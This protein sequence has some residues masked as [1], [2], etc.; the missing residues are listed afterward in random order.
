M[1]DYQRT[2]RICTLAELPAS[3]GAALTQ[4]AQDLGVKELSQQVLLCAE[5]ISIKKKRTGFIQ[6][7]LGGDPDINHITGIVVTSQY[8]IWGHEGEKRGIT[9]LSAKLNEVRVT[10][11][12]STLVPDSG[13]EIFGFISGVSEKVQA[14]IGVGEGAAA[15]QLRQIIAQLT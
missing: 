15:D 1:S 14:F 6:R 9:V 11:F 7:L 3:L 12:T 2:T 10:P 8:L 4:R 5:T 13:L